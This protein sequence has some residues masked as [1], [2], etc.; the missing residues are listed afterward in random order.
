MLAIPTLLGSF[1][2]FVVAVVYIRVAIFQS[3]RGGE[4][5]PKGVQREYQLIENSNNHICYLIGTLYLLRKM[6]DAYGFNED[7]IF[8]YGD[9]SVINSQPRDPQDYEYV[10]RLDKVV[11]KGTYEDFKLRLIEILK[12][13]K[14]SHDHKKINEM[15]RTLET[16][17]IACVK[18]YTKTPTVLSAR[19][20][21]WYPKESSF[22]ISTFHMT[23][24]N[25]FTGGNTTGVMDLL[26][27]TSDML[28]QSI[29][30]TRL[31]K[32]D[33]T[34]AMITNTLSTDDLLTAKPDTE[35]YH[36]IRRIDRPESNVPIGRV[37]DIFVSGIMN[38]SIAILK[39]ED[40][41]IEYDSTNNL[42]MFKGDEISTFAGGRDRQILYAL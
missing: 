39:E 3:K 10:P 2:T 12:L 21:L 5:L 28:R 32:S 6:I 27:F 25:N 19:S 33:K 35:F 24:A 36:E 17:Y 4:R 34:G 26:Y 8:E 42:S 30:I 41:W 31:M 18:K 14:S 7:M 16:K 23:N 9:S 38:H 11:D 40:R 22:M 1:I 20:K 29:S 15:T 37:T 13:L